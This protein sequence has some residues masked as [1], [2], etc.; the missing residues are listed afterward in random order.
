MSLI[1]EEMWKALAR[2]GYEAYAATTGNKNIRGDEMPR[3]DELP[4]ETVAA[5]VAAVRASVSAFNFV[6]EDALAQIRARHFYQIS[7]V[8][9]GSM[10]VKEPV[11]CALELDDAGEIAETLARRFV[12]DCLVEGFI[13]K[14]HGQRSILFPTGYS[15]IIPNPS[16]RAPRVK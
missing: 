11:C 7:T 16:G 15:F 5:W 10:S 3:F 1:M 9:Y 6:Q 13:V 14:S 2:T 8:R 4:S 12:S